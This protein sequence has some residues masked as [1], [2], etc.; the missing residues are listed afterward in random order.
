MAIWNKSNQPQNIDLSLAG[1]NDFLFTAGATAVIAGLLFPAGA[2][3]LDIVLIFSMCL[4]AALLIITC[5]ARAILEVSG[6]PLLIL[7]ASMLRMA[8]T[9]AA[10]KLILSNA[11]AGNIIALAGGIVIRGGG[12][13]TIL[14]LASLLA[15]V[16]ISVWRTS[17]KIGRAGADFATDIVPVRQIGIENNLTTGAIDK[18]KA[19]RLLRNLA[20]EADF[21]FAMVAAARFMLCTAFV[22]L[23]A[24]AAGTAAALIMGIAG[25]ASGTM[26]VTMYSTLIAGAAIITQSSALLVTLASRHLTLK[27]LAVPKEYE[28]VNHAWHE[29][30][31]RIKIVGTQ[32]SP[33]APDHADNNINQKQHA[34]PEPP[35]YFDAEFDEIT[36]PSAVDDKYPNDHQSLSEETTAWSQTPM[37]KNNHIE[38]SDSCFW[39]REEIESTGSYDAIAG[40]IESLPGDSAK[41]VLMA[42]E[43]LDHLGV[44]IPVNVAI[45]LAKNARSCLLIDLDSQRAALSKVFDIEEPQTRA[46]PVATCIKNLSVCLADCFTGARSADIMEIIT[47][48]KRKYDNLII[49]APD[50]R[51]H[52]AIVK[53]AACTRTAILF[54]RDTESETSVM[55]DFQNLLHGYGCDILH[56]DQILAQPV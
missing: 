20:R 24:I 40:L 55:R 19:D 35:E 56:P 46:E 34:Y 13:I 44:N 6:F 29:Q 37:P 14:I 15:V 53:I 18:N 42:A 54:E 8:L 39:S 36:H 52:T 30:G 16:Y 2:H 41:T 43:S 9:V 17:R 5:S 23:L 51:T 48:F 47:R 22:E 38:Q 31:K 50:I 10:V 3:L 11:D 28:S 27:N 21:F 33:A 26:S 45:R 7:A 4:T 49:Y 12:I 1:R 25:P 32:V